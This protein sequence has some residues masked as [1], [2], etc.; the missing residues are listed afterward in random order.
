MLITR[1]SA[2]LSAATVTTLGASRPARAAETMKIGVVSPLTGPVAEAGDVDNRD[3]LE[4]QHPLVPD[5]VLLAQL[6]LLFEVLSP[7]MGG[8]GSV[9]SGFGGRA[10]GFESQEGE[11]ASRRGEG[12]ESIAAVVSPPPPP[13]SDAHSVPRLSHRRRRHPRTMSAV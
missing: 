8:R 13:N 10:G 2:L 1:R 11:G 7:T 5:A 12:A 9:S 3:H 4:G 6:G